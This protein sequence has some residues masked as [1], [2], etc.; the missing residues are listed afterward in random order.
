MLARRHSHQ[1]TLD[2]GP[3]KAAGPGENVGR[4]SAQ[5]WMTSPSMHVIDGGGTEDTMGHLSPFPPLP[6]RRRPNPSRG[7]LKPGIIYLFYLEMR[8]YRA[9]KGCSCGSR[10]VRRGPNDGHNGEPGVKIT[11]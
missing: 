3:E 4:W 1:T 11:S 6:A 7:V 2:R 10:G 9:L 8:L 5:G